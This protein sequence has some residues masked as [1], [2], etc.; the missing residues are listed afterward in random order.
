MGLKCCGLNRLTQATRLLCILVTACL[1]FAMLGE[2]GHAEA[3]EEVCSVRSIA[4]T[5]KTMSAF[6]KVEQLSNTLLHAQSQAL[7]EMHSG[8]VVGID[9]GGFF[10][11]T[12]TLSKSTGKAQSELKAL[13]ISA[14]RLNWDVTT[15]EGFADAV[16]SAE[17]L[18]V[19]GF[20]I[21]DYL[22]KGQIPEAVGIYAQG[23]LLH[24]KRV[25]ATVYSENSGN[26]REIAVLS[27]KCR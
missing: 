4:S 9:D 22:E 15:A 25:F 12:G 6:R 20:Q 3:T 8:L 23:S 17:A 24:Y 5:V 1:C 18:I 27:A 19:A 13:A 26:E 7:I 14:R 2:A 10:G 16:A 11:P 21:V